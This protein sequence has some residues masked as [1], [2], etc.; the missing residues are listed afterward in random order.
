MKILTKRAMTVFLGMVAGY[1][2]LHP[3]TML[4][5]SLSQIHQ[6]GMMRFQWSDW[7]KGLS[8]KVNA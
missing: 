8:A 7:Q 5:H 6:D 3:Y 1:V 2:I 4:A